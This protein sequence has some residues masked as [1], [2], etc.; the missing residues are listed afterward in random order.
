MQCA[1][2]LRWGIMA[3]ILV[4]INYCNLQLIVSP[5]AWGLMFDIREKIKKLIFN[6]L[7]SKNVF[8]E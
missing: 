2:S 8:F 4:Y 7:I 3:C 1:L 5:E 6:S